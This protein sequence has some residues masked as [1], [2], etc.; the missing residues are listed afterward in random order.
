MSYYIILASILFLY[1]SLWFIFSLVKKRN[2]FADVAWG[3]G[4]ILMAWSSFFIFGDGSQKSIIVNVL[5]TIWGLRL[6]WH[7]GSRN[8]SKKED[9]RYSAWRK[10]WGKWFYIRSYFQIYLFQGFLLFI[11]SLPILII[12]SAE[13]APFEL[14]DFLGISVWLLGFF[15]E[16]LG[17]YQLKIFTQNPLNKGKLLQTGLWGITR[18]PNYFGEVVLWWG[19]GLLAVTTPGGWLALIGPLTISFLII[20]VSGIPMLEKK[21][22]KNPEFKEYKR[23]VSAF[24]PMP[25]KNNY[26][27]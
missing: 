6:A 13:K 19:I 11:V 20:K 3:L 1:M 27:K 5:V 7:I 17:D 8:K 24:F 9:Y 10:D 18:H 4:F 26:A 16:A 21:M 12:N 2:D 14:L 25:Q 22:A 23:K 15:F